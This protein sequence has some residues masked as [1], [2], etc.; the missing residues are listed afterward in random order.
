[1]DWLPVMTF[2]TSLMTLVATLLKPVMKRRLFKSKCCQICEVVVDDPTK[3]E[4][5]DFNQNKI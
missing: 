2:A 1:M 3:Q 4:V 5:I